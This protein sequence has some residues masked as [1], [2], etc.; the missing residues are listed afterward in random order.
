MSD[1]LMFHTEITFK[2]MKSGS[3]TV[4]LLLTVLL[5]NICAVCG[6]IQSEKSMEKKKH[7][8]DST[9]RI[10]GA[11]ILVTEGVQKNLERIKRAIDYA[12]KEKADILVTPE[13]ALSGY[14]SAFDSNEVE[15]A[16]HEIENYAKDAGVG[17]ALGICRYETGHPKPF[18]QVRMYTDEGDCLGFHSKI[19]RC[20]NMKNPEPGE[21]ELNLYETSELHIFP[22][23]QKKVGVLVCN[24]L[25][26]N[27]EW[28][29]MSD[30][31]LTRQLANM[32]AQVILHATNTG[33]NNSEWKEVYQHFHRSNLR[34]RARVSKIWI[35]SVDAAVEGRKPCLN[36]S[37]VINPNGEV[38]FEVSPEG[39]QLFVFTIQ[40]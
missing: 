24:D 39:E 6:Q 36:P 30:P 7:K 26:A 2:K 15:N 20:S 18:N 37:C 4:I 13:G 21:E 5:I 16:L 34:M 3:T 35:I 33:T 12:K 23:Q 32:G 1:R 19:L 11:Q 40:L 9:L 22:F 31:H 29:S 8:T 38:L 28:T 27:P 17:L 10:A 25:W 14:T